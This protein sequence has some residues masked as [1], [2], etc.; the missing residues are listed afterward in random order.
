VWLT[1]ARAAARGG[2]RAQAEE[3]AASY[4]SLVKSQQDIQALLDFI[5]EDLRRNTLAAEF[6]ADGLAFDS[7][8]EARKRRADLATQLWDLD[9]FMVL[10][11]AYTKALEGG[12]GDFELLYEGAATDVQLGEL[13][14]ARNRLSRAAEIDPLKIWRQLQIDGRFLLLEA[15]GASTQPGASKNG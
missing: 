3:Y 6:N 4:V 1:S 9:E 10:S 15:D 12:P 14:T 11:N 8:L 2:Q 7:S 13:P 5:E